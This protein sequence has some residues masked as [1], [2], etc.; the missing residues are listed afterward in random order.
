[1]LKRRVDRIEKK[2]TVLTKTRVVLL[3]PEKQKYKDNEFLV[4]RGESDIIFIEIVG[5]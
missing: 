4:K 3:H 1:M 5:I 2:S